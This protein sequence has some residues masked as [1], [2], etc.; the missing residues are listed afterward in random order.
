M[1]P[2]ERRASVSVAGD[3]IEIGR[4]QI[5]MDEKRT[6]HIK[7]HVLEARLDEPRTK[8]AIGIGRKETKGW[9][10]VRESMSGTSQRTYTGDSLASLHIR[11][12]N[13]SIRQ[14]GSRMSLNVQKSVQKRSSK[15][16]L[17][18]GQPSI[19]QSN[20]FVIPEASDSR[21]KLPVTKEELVHEPQLRQGWKVLRETIKRKEFHENLQVRTSNLKLHNMDE[22]AFSRHS[23]LSNRLPA[24][25]SQNRRN[26]LGT[27]RESKYGYEET[28]VNEH[29]RKSLAQMSNPTDSELASLV[30][31]SQKRSN[32]R[33]RCLCLP[34]I[35]C[36]R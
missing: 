8:E 20:C 2:N 14:P 34:P 10:I 22:V 4:L 19:R 36:R 11:K 17:G 24:N 30:R 12:S 18:G 7:N 33:M 9:K 16:S 1:F 21:H 31:L 27:R 35:Y 29:R 15:L 3:G 6:S 23:Q 5:H 13:L 28:S 26:S 32:H 25:S